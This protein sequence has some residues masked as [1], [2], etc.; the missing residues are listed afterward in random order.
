MKEQHRDARIVGVDQ[1][2]A[3]LR[4][5]RGRDRSIE[6]IAG[7]IRKPAVDGRFD[8]II[9][10]FNTIQLLLEDRDLLQVFA[11]ACA[12]LNVE[13]RFAFDLYQPNPDYL[14]AP[15]NDRVTRTVRDAE[16]RSLGVHERARYDAETKVLTVRWRLVESSTS[17]ETAAAE[18][19]MRQYEAT[20]IERLVRSAGLVVVESYGDYDRTPLAKTSSKQLFV[21]AASH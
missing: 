10:C 8:L 19:Q 17:T 6:W 20:E 5:A 14:R 4:V 9:C 18:F 21:C 15:P 1:S 3:M 13:G 12:L 11:A 16:G 2:D 7:D